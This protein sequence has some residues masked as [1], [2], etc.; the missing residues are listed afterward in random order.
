MPAP[1]WLPSAGVRPAL[2]LLGALLVAC[3]SAP[4]EQMRPPPPPTTA[5]SPAPT[6]A[7]RQQSPPAPSRSS[8]P[9]P[10]APSASPSAATL[11]AGPA[12]VAVAVATVWRAPSAA[13]PVDAPALANPVRMRQ[14]LATMTLPQR[15]DLVGRVDTQAL[16]GERVTVTGVVGSWAH[17]VVP[18][19][20]TPLD[21]RGYP[22]WVPARQLIAGEPA[23]KGTWLVVTTLTTWL[24]V[25]DGSAME[26]SFGTRLVAVARVGTSWTVGLPSGRAATVAASAV[27]LEALPSRPDAVVASARVFLGLPYLWG[28]TAGFGVDCSGLTYLVYRVHG[29]PIPRDADAQVNAG[30][31]VG[32]PG[33]ADLV[34]FASTSGNVQHV[35]VVESPRLMIEAPET[36]SVVRVTPLRPYT[37]VRRIV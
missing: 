31:A 25:D 29:H 17:V 8:P 20:A 13:R 14:W 33:P 18:D 9:T 26:V 11:T 19:Q 6:Q 24:R 4:G 34:F 22:G 21:P 12:V 15:R 1:A 28:G 10:A 16:L 3:G 2:A 30:R 35:G 7:S 5:N 27:D 23:R 36:G 32:A 37:F